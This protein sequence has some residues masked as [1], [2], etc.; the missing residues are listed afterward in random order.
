[1]FGESDFR[2]GFVSLVGRP[3]AGKSSLINAI[4]GEKLAITSNT[5]QTTRHKFRAI[6]DS[7]DAQIIFVDTPGL[8]KPHD[9][10]GEELNRSAIKSLEDIDIV[11]FC[12]DAS[13]P[14][15]SGDKRVLDALKK[16]S[17][18]RLLIVTKTDLADAEAIQKQI[19]ETGDY[20]NFDAS[21]AVSAQNQEGI[22]ECLKLI[23]TAL[24]LG[25]RWFPE[26]TKTDQPIEVLISEFIR[27]KVLL[28]TRDEVPHA[29][30]VSIDDMNYN[31]KKDLSSI[32]ATIYVERDSQ[33]GI[34]IGKGGSLIKEIGSEARKDLE[35]MLGNKVFLD[36]RVKIKKDW[37]RDANQIRRFGY[38]EGL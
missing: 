8:H 38:G 31:E 2:S 34:I 11:A 35:H 3:N 16:L 33:K 25:P 28:L 26:G 37:R 19:D 36:L 7:D 6:Y 12:L 30:G 10:L 5:P 21:V 27:E 18:Y 14:F 4:M 32:Y 29:V 23:E 22:D 1:M 13:K 24:P 9:A 17:C 15:G 20:F